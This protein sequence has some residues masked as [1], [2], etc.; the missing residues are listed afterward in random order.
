M[1]GFDWIEIN[2]ISV[3]RRGDREPGTGWCK[4]LKGGR[5]G[6][7]LLRVQMLG[8]TRCGVKR[9]G[10]DPRDGWFV[11]DALSKTRNIAGTAFCADLRASV[12]RVPRSTCDMHLDAK[13]LWKK[14]EGPDWVSRSKLYFSHVFKSCDSQWVLSSK[15]C[16]NFL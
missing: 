13:S 12:E 16:Y 1:A 4:H 8:Q 14:K 6:T 5:I 10:P 2:V 15:C 3:R 9:L 11:F 7:S